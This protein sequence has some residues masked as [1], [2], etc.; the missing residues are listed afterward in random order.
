MLFK[1]RQLS[2]NSTREL[3]VELLRLVL[4]L[5]IITQHLIFHATD[6][7]SVLAKAEG[8]K[9]TTYI[10]LFFYSLVVC[11]VNCFVFIS[12]YYGINFSLKKLLLLVLEG[13]FYAVLIPVVLFSVGVIEK[14]QID[15]TLMF[16]PVSSGLWW[17]LTAYVMLFVIS[18][19]INSGFEVL[20]QSQ[21]KLVL[22]LLL[23]GDAFYGFVFYG[24]TGDAYNVLHFIVMY[25]LARYISVY[26][27]KIPFPRRW[28]F[29]LFILMLMCCGV[30]V[31]F[32]KTGIICRFFYYHNPIIILMSVTLFFM[33]K[34]MSIKQKWV[35][36][37]SSGV[38]GVY[39]F[40]DHY[41]IREYYTLLLNSL[42]DVLVLPF[43]VLF[44]ILILFLGVLIDK[45]RQ[46]VFSFFIFLT[47]FVKAI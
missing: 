12:G 44:P 36:W 7:N 13:V 16:L 28:F 33:F 38:L 5:M 41:L 34:Q 3:N 35:S 46:K 39:L 15:F 26:K 29:F 4:K 42:D 6:F 31:V 37:A 18:P 32:Q 20:P 11:A 22:M 19:F 8:L 14:D 27:V 21:V 2:N 25:C 10:Q 23:L 24:F 40:H 43:V 30:L 47:S 9:V 45:M 17:F 1:E